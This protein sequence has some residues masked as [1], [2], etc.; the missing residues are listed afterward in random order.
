MEEEN[1]VKFL[2]EAMRMLNS[3]MEVIKLSQSKN[4]L[5][6]DSWEEKVLNLKEETLN[7]NKELAT[8]LAGLKEEDEV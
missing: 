2:A 8:H 6:T 4:I 3:S 1:A 5:F 7:F